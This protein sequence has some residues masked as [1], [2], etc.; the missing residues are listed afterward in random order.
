MK[1][2]LTLL[3]ALALAATACLGLVA[4]KSKTPEGGNTEN[5]GNDA[6]AN[7]L[8]EA[9]FNSIFNV[10]STI[11]DGLFAEDTDYRADITRSR[12]TATKQPG[13]EDD[14]PRV[15]VSYE[16]VTK[17]GNVIKSE[18]LQKEGEQTQVVS[19]V[20]RRL[21]KT[22]SG[23][24]NVEAY[25]AEGRPNEYESEE[26]CPSM[27]LM[28]YVFGFVTLERAIDNLLGEMMLETDLSF[29]LSEFDFDA[30]AGKYTLK[31]AK[32]INYDGKLYATITKLEVSVA[33]G[34]IA[35]VVMEQTEAKGGRKT[36][37]NATLTE[38]NGSDVLTQE[39]IISTEEGVVA[40]EDKTKNVFTLTPTADGKL[41]SM[42]GEA[43]NWQP[44]GE[45]ESEE[46][47]ANAEYEYSL[48]NTATATVE[49]AADGKPAK[50]TYTNVRDVAGQAYVYT[51]LQEIVFTYADQ[52]ATV[53]SIRR[54]KSALPMTC[55]SHMMFGLAE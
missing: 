7:V 22:E 18:R 34:R 20:Y 11:A 37:V 47:L 36:T 6:N 45:I 17:D 41:A 2:F 13:P 46:D 44:K 29:T 31:E 28:S 55:A 8:T 51:S 38:A 27:F 30:A 25:D 9:Q 50:L 10:K 12:T 4:C 48:F 42:V 14:G 49:Y 26:E 39:V 43:Y 54:K 33:G 32:P 16:T 23:K 1:R 3:L 24:F 21:T 40:K 5:G 15:D 19:T 35:T 53:R 52:T